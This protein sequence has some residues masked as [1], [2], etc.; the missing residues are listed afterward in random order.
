MQ[1]MR[2]RH[3]LPQAMIVELALRSRHP[4]VSIGRLGHRRVSMRKPI[5]SARHAYMT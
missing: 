1:Q 3:A 2:C 4:R 5:A